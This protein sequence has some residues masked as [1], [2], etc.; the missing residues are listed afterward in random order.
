MRKQIQFHR[1]HLCSS[2][3]QHPQGACAGARTPVNPVSP[4]TMVGQE[5]YFTLYGLGS[6]H[7]SVLTSEGDVATLEDLVFIITEETAPASFL[8]F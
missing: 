3:S 6:E 5:P 4:K 7:L 8:R 1:L 2:S